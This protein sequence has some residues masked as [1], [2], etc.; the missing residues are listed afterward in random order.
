MLYQLSE[1]HLS[2]KGEL[3]VIFLPVPQYLL[4]VWLFVK[5][6]QYRLSLENVFEL[7]PLVSVH[8]LKYQR[9]NL[10]TVVVN[11]CKL[12]A[13]AWDLVSGPGS[14]Q[15]PMVLGGAVF[16]GKFE[17]QESLEFVVKRSSRVAE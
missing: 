6:K 8:C 12:F 11:C 2:K 9:H 17:N 16:A 5:L 14:C 15:L 1:S 3:Y 13:S 10:V 7:Q 4:S